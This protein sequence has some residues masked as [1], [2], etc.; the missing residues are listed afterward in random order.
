M[1]SQFGRLIALALLV[2]FC[3][4]FVLAEEP[5]VFPTSPRYYIFTVTKSDLRQ[6]RRTKLP[7]LESTFRDQAKNVSRFNR[8]DSDHVWEGLRL[9]VPRLSAD[10]E[11]T[12]MPAHYPPAANSPKFVL[13][14]LTKQFLGLYEHGELAASYPISSGKAGTPTPTGDFR[15]TGHDSDHASSLY[16]E[17]TGGWPMPWAIRFHRTEYWLHGGALPGR[18]DSHG[19][20][21]LLPMDA[22][23]LFRSTP[24]GTPVKIIDNL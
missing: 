12:P 13:V 6:A 2:M 22:E 4:S 3:S 8:R 24:L 5:L 17:P 14:W 15:V 11:Y 9:K 21:R 10:Q 16:P 1:W 19:C 18:P 7:V 23:A 20:V